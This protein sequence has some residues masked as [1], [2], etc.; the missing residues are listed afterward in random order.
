MAIK[1]FRFPKMPKPKNLKALFRGKIDLDKDKLF[2][3]SKKAQGIHDPLQS[4]YYWPPSV[5]ILL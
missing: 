2:S 3:H 1:S 4:I 5:M